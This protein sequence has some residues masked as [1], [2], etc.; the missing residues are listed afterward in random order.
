MIIVTGA[1]HTSEDRL[2][3]AV[4]LSLAHV[5]RSRLEPGCISHHLHLDAEDRCRLVF[6]ERW[7]SPEALAAHFA[8]PESRAFV[9]ALSALAVKP[10]EMEIHHVHPSEGPPA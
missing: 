10:P 4:A 6:L 2:E 7:E 5:R 3:E 9:R 1:V 8:A